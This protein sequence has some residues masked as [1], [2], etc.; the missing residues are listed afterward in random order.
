MDK[1]VPIGELAVKG[2]AEAAGNF[3]MMQSAQAYAKGDENTKDAML[4][5]RNVAET[6]GFI[7]S[8]VGHGAVYKARWHD[9]V[10]SKYAAKELAGLISDKKLKINDLHLEKSQLAQKL[11]SCG[12]TDDRKLRAC[13]R[14]ADIVYDFCIVRKN[15]WDRK[16]LYTKEACGRKKEYKDHMLSDG[17]FDI[18]DKKTRVIIKKSLRSSKSP[19]IKELSKKDLRDKKVLKKLIKDHDRY[20]LS[21][22]DVS[23]LRLLLKASSYD[24]AK[25]RARVFSAAKVGIKRVVIRGA[26]KSSPNSSGLKRCIYKAGTGTLAAGYMK[27]TAVAVSTSVHEVARKENFLHLKDLED[28]AKKYVKKHTKR[29]RD[30]ERTREERKKVRKRGQALARRK[31][32]ISEKLEGLSFSLASPF[33]V[34][35]NG[36]AYGAEA[37]FAGKRA[38]AIGV[39]ILL[40]MALCMVM[41][42]NGALNLILAEADAFLVDEEYI[43]DSGYEPSEA[44][45]DEDMARI[46]E[47]CKDTDGLRNEVASYALSM[48]GQI[49][50]YWGGKPTSGDYEDNDFFSYVPPDTKG[51]TAK[52]LDCSGFVKFVYWH[53]LGYPLNANNTGDF[54]G[55]QFKK[56]YDSELKP[57][58]VGLLREGYS[59]GSG[60]ANHIGIFVGRD[61]SGN[62][63]FVHCTGAPRNIVVCGM[64]NFKVF[65]RI[66][67]QEE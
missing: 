66:I 43:D 58:D 11:I 33:R 18:R 27:N 48:V 47:S 40:A 9:A 3:V 35:N 4:A 56:V 46:L 17:F 44:M 49:P 38:F 10:G 31:K 55:G 51:R 54:T 61:E 8:C 6:A 23:A 28:N 24:E 45:T 39:G 1:K 64:Q 25:S 2:S 42:V 26:L 7:T 60:N 57:G 59:T 53:V 14:N 13:L 67:P 50:Y 65:Y 62:A 20:G 52:G 29:K 30:P 15:I 37:I 21:T 63:I 16:L 19:V 36:L 41:M 34:I 5:A 32:M 12:I 22:S